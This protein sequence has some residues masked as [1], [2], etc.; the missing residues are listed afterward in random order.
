VRLA[1]YQKNGVFEA[2]QKIGLRPEEFRWEGEGDDDRLTH[3][4]SRAYFV[5]GGGAGNHLVRYAAGA[6]P[7]EER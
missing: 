2:I 3:L 6:A 5:F 7:M 1:K 4:A